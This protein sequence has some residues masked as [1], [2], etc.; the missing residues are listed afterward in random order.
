[1]LTLL[2]RWFVAGILAL[3]PLGITAWVLVKVFVAVEGN[4]APWVSRWAGYELPGLGFLVTI[5]F[6]LLVGVFASNI[7]GSSVIH[8]FEDLFAKLPLI[9]RIYLVVKQIGEGVLG[10]KRNLFERVVMFE[11]P[12][13]GS[14]AIGFLT[15]EHD[16]PIAERTGK[17]FYHVFVP[18]TPNP[19]SGFLLFLPADD[20]IG[21]DISVEDGLKLVI[22]GGAVSPARIGTRVFGPMSPG[23][24]TIEPVAPVREDV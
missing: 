17:K 14:W 9:S 11:Y 4:V 20:L 3:L 21:L 18:T 10:S 6:V 19:T 22:S 8:R 23:G 15:S 1:M 24:T 2:R 5:L 13:R 12:R 16:G 7:I